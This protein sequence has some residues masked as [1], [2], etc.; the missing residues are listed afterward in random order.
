M[1]I[2]LHSVHVQICAGI[3]T[4]KMVHFGGTQDGTPDHGPG[5]DFRGF[6][7][8]SGV[9]D[10]SRAQFVGFCVC[11][12]VCVMYLY[13]QCDIQIYVICTHMCKYSCAN[14]YQSRMVCR[15]VYRW[16]T[17]GGLF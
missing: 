4:P 2:S 12:Y 13:I 10:G 3:Y 16:C 17:S 1:R 8:V 11:M 6:E 7:V 14:P 5:P 15:Y 9:R